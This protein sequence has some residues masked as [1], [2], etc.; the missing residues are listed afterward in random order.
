MADKREGK[1]SGASVNTVS[2]VLQECVKTLINVTE[3]LDGFKPAFVNK[4]FYLNLKVRQEKQLSVWCKKE[5]GDFTCTRDIH[6]RFR[7]WQTDIKPAILLWR[8][9]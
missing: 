3:R 6:K 1:T 8:K 5:K 9:R 4:H 7:V 2:S